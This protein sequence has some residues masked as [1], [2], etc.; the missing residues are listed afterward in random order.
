MKKWMV[1]GLAVWLVSGPTQADD[2]HQAAEDLCE[3]V[4]GCAIK[5]MGASELTP[6]MRQ[7][8]EPMLD[9]MCEGMNARIGQVPTDHVLHDPALA[10]MRSMEKLGCALVENGGN[11]ETPECNKYEELA[12][13][14]GIEQP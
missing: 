11:V 10:C 3:T 13:Q 6:E 5:Q 4:K 9:K 7:M 14:Q 2:F 8:M 1:L 12:R